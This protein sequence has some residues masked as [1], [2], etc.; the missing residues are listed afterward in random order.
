MAYLKH[1]DTIKEKLSENHK[2]LVKIINFGRHNKM[3]AN[4]L[5]K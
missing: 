4:I 1:N 2:N 3:K 5:L